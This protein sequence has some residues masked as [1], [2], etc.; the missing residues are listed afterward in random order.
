MGQPPNQFLWPFFWTTI[1]ENGR[2]SVLTPYLGYLH[3][4]ERFIDKAQHCTLSSQLGTFRDWLQP[5]QCNL[6]EGNKVVLSIE[7]RLFLSLMDKEKF[8][9][10]TNYCIAPF[11]FKSLLQRLPNDREQALSCFNSL[12]Y[13]LERKPQIKIHLA[14]WCK[15]CFMMTRLSYL[16]LLNRILQTYLPT[17]WVPRVP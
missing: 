1:F 17:I 2:P 8:I 3:V 13:T 10:S 4:K 7:D 12:C 14:A 15:R 11:S 6:C 9:E 5:K 16:Q